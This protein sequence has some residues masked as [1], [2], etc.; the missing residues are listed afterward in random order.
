M[1][2]AETTDELNAA[3]NEEAS[4]ST[5][6]AR[7]AEASSLTLQRLETHRVAEANAVEAAMLARDSAAVAE[8]QMTRLEQDVTSQRQVEASVSHALR[9]EQDV[10]W[11]LQERLNVAEHRCALA[12]TRANDGAKS[13]ERSRLL[14]R[15][16]KE[17]AQELRIQLELL[18]EFGRE[19][20]MQPARAAAASNGVDNKGA[21]D[22]SMHDVTTPKGGMSPVGRRKSNELDDELGAALPSVLIGVEL[23]LGLGRK[24][25]L[26]VAPW[27]TR[28]DFDKIVET[29]LEDNRIKPFFKDALV[30]YLVDVDNEAEAFPATVHASLSDIYTNFG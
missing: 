3:R 14:E 29:F 17:R 26:T 10:A 24:A 8:A 11:E 12:E 23:D 20:F 27:Q 19:D 4:L 15:Q 6:V 25:T 1:K 2:V 28:A 21:G 22:S 30:H 18:R 9:Q 7:N 5:D 13:L 16:A